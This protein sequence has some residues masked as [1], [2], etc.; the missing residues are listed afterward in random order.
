MQSLAKELGVRE[1]ILEYRDEVIRHRRYL[2]LSTRTQGYLSD[3]LIPRI[4]FHS[5]FYF[6]L[7]VLPLGISRF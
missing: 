4:L 7:L 1:E 2:H 5:V 6:T 3:L